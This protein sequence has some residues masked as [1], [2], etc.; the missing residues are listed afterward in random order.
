MA[1][2]KTSSDF[3]DSV[4]PNIL[5]HMLLHSISIKTPLMIW[6]QPG[7]GKS[8]TV[9][10][11]AQQLGRPLIDIRLPLMEP[12]DMR[13]IPYLADI[14]TYDKRG[15]LVRDE[16]GVP[17]LEKECRWSPP[18]DLPRDESSKAIVF[19]DE[20]SSAT[21]SVQAATYQIVLNRRIG[22]YELPKDAAIVAAGNRVRDRGVA[23]NMP[24]AL[25]NRFVHATL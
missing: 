4:G 9:A 6:G 11:V 5:K 24:S 3:V 20:L 19:Y 13:G 10:Q 2:G 1:K 23:Y 8:D 14:K 15:N 21:P 18:I 7:I 16:Q 12:T 25:R 17:I 22:N